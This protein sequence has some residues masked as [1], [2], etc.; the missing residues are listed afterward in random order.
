MKNKYMIT[1]LCFNLLIM[2]SCRLEKTADIDIITD[3]ITN[4]W[5]AYDK[6]QT[7]QDSVLKM[8]YLKESFLDKGTDGLRGMMKVKGSTLKDYF[9]AINK[10]PKFWNSIRENTNKVDEF[11]LKLS[12]G[13]EKLRKIYPNLKPAK[14]YFTISPLKSNGTTLNNLVF[15]GSELAMADENTVSSELPGREGKGRRAFFDSN[16]IHDLVL[17]NVHEYV[18][19]QQNVAVNNLLSYVIREGVAEFVSVKAM[20]IPSAT[21]AVTYSKQNERVREWFEQE[22]FYGNNLYE[23]LWSDA[24]NEFGVRDLGYG[25][26]YELCEKYYEQA[27]DK[28]K[29]IEKMIILDFTNKTE[30][31]NFVDEA[32]YFS[33]TLENLYQQFENKRPKVMRVKPFENNHQ[34]VDSKINKLTIKFSEPMNQEF[35][36]FDFGPL[37]KDASI[38]IKKII[39]FSEDG[40]SLTF[41]IEDLKPN[42]RYQLIIGSRFQ[43]LNNVPL[44]SYLI[45]FKTK[46]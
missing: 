9:N 15:I 21:P 12:E 18:H 13:V 30:I 6:M 27:P 35:R 17:L 2:I 26:G 29:A 1:I 37:G 20:G 25:I 4:F 36:N 46:D 44:K 41:A 19:A 40:K 11:S 32:G 3:D 31:E 38:K 5:T 24:T 28:K 10:Y 8:K 22:L 14:I 43:N 33:E 23:W 45:D 16:P 34:E 39:G 42:K 7:T